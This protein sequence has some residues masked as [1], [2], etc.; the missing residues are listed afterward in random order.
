MTDKET[1]RY[2]ITAHT[3]VPKQNENAQW[4]QRVSVSIVADI[5][6]RGSVVEAQ[7]AVG[8]LFGWQPGTY[9][10]WLLPDAPKEPASE[11]P[12]SESFALLEKR[13]RQRA[14][15]PNGFNMKGL[16]T[17]SLA[18]WF[19]AVTGELGEASNLGKK[20]LRYDT[21]VNGN[22][23]QLKVLEANLKKEI[24]DIGA[25]LSLLAQSRGYTLQEV[26]QLVYDTKSEELGYKEEVDE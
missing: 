1:R 25:Y 21:N 26:M 4:H 16:N 8:K 3:T 9:Q 14:V 10:V 15:S 20:I 11:K 17:W 5:H 6:D 12:A 22:T 13:M 19:M 2:Q 24:G 7:C 23:E 18:E